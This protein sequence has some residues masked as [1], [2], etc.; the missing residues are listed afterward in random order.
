M[1]S[2]NTHTSIATLAAV[3]V[4]AG[5]A[6]AGL[7]LDL[8]KWTPS[9]IELGAASVGVIIGDLFLSPDLDGAASN[10]KRRWGPLR[11][12]WRLYE[13]LPHRSP[14]SHWPILGDAG[15]LVY[16]SAV[17]A[18]IPVGTGLARD[19]LQGAMLDTFWAVDR[20]SAMILAYPRES[21]AAFA[22]LCLATF[23]HG[24]ADWVV[25]EGKKMVDYEAPARP[26]GGRPGK[27]AV[28]PAPMSRKQQERLAREERRRPANVG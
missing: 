23:L 24:V 21:G 26:K 10:A 13:K 28:N 20:A 3:A 8:G 17:L 18:P 14:L 11:F 15:R 19:G 25:S 1:P 12:I 9:V 22:G 16:L 2:G 7:Y 4:F 6:A 5:G 27:R